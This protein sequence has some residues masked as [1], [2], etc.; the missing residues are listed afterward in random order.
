M[1]D[2][3]LAIAAVA[4][5]A[6]PVILFFVMVDDPWRRTSDRSRQERSAARR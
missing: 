6:T 3:I 4:F 1:F 5:I 2:P